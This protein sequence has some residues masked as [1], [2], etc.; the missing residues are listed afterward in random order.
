MS[1][2]RLEVPE[3]RTSMIANLLGVLVERR[4]DERT[5]RLM[6]GRVP[7]VIEDI[8]CCLLEVFSIEDVKICTSANEVATCSRIKKVLCF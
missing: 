7:I 4:S 5:S 3:S 2:E 1:S 6:R 8:L